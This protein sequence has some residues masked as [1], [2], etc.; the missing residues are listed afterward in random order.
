MNEIRTYIKNHRD[1]L[2]DGFILPE[3]TCQDGFR[4]SVQCGFGHY[5]EP[6]VNKLGDI[7]YITNGSEVIS[8]TDGL[9]ENPVMF[10]LG[11]PSKYESLLKPYQHCL[12]YHKK[13]FK[14][15]IFGWVPM[16]VV[17]EI[18]KK[19]GGIKSAD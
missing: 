1:N 17:E 6:E 2:I 10:E 18:L 4:I 12:P 9:P 15:H 13:N 19:H 7:Y 14:K 16:S 3:I 11:F 5:S 8:L